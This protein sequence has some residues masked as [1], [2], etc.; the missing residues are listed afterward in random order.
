MES[1][2]HYDM[3][4]EFLDDDVVTLPEFSSCV[5]GTT[6]SREGDEILLYSEELILKSLMANS[7]MSRE[8]AIEYFEF[9]IAGAYVGPKTPMYAYNLKERIK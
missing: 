1:E 6:I 4:S 2:T 5:I 7:E 3:I 8:D 9:N